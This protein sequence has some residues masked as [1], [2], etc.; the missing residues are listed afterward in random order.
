MYWKYFF[1]PQYSI[2]ALKAI[3]NFNILKHPFN[4]GSGI[5]N[6]AAA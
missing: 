6:K 1:K 3:I 2:I 4:N 5:E